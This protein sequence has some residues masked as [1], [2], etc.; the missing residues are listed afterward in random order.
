MKRL[1]TNHVDVYLL[2]GLERQ[3]WI[4]MRRLGALE[5]LDRI[6]ADGRVR[7]TGFSYHD[8]A[9]SL[10]EDRRQL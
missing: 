10:Q 4:R 9:E 1:D 5:F 8:D 6:R 2:H 3:D 7:Y